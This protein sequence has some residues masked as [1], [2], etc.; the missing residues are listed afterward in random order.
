VSNNA[1]KDYLSICDDIPAEHSGLIFEQI[2]RAAIVAV[3]VLRSHGLPLPGET[4]I[5]TLPD[6]KK[7]LVNLANHALHIYF[8][9]KEKAPKNVQDDEIWGEFD[10]DIFELVVTG[11]PS[12][13]F[14]VQIDMNLLYGS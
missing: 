5:P 8:Y 14:T 12:G 7:H 2:H 4:K 11:L 6:V 13:G 10:D 9:T 3:T 1:V